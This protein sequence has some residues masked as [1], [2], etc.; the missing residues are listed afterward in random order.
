[1]RPKWRI[2]LHGKQECYAVKFNGTVLARK[3]PVLLYVVGEAHVN[4]KLLGISLRIVT[5]TVPSVEE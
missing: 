1:M 5:P 4:E 3:G 2:S